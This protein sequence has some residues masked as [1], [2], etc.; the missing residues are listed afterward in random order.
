MRVVGFV[1]SPRKGGNTQLLVERVLC[2][3]A[4]LGARTSIYFLNELN[5]RGC[6]AC[7]HCKEYRE[8][9]QKDDMTQ[10]YNVIR[11]AEGL[12]I[13]SPIYMDYLSAQTKLFIDRLFAFLGPNLCCTL[14]RGKRVVLVYS[15]GGGNNPEVMESL[16]RFLEG[17]LGME[18]QGIVGGN[19][20]NELGAVKDRKDLLDR[21]FALGQELLSR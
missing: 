1:G 18:V 8:C 9:R 19:G 5:I 21:A 2:G 14:P 4:S 15:Q 12:V 13:G 11:E 6:Q 10:L 7:H 17:A 3:A 16:A 20:L